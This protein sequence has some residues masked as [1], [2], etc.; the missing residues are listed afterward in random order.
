MIKKKKWIS[1]IL[2]RKLA[3]QL[4]GMGLLLI[5][6]GLY[7]FFY[8]VIAS[9]YVP[10]KEQAELGLEDKIE[11]M[12]LSETGSALPQMKSRTEPFNL[13]IVTTAFLVVGL[14]CFLLSFRTNN[15]LSE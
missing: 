3:L 1:D 9:P 2:H 4:R 6:F 11:T 5:S 15:K 14:S 13:Y 8:A 12:G 7:A 10:Q